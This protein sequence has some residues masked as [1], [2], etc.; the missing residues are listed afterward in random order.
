MTTITER[1]RPKNPESGFALSLELLLIALVL[2][3]GLISGWV[4]FRDSSG[5]EI[6]DAVAA[7]DA[8]I[9]GVAP[10]AQPYA[11]QWIT[12]AGTV[13]CSPTLSPQPA[14]CVAPV[15]EIIDPDG[16]PFAATGPVALRYQTG[17]VASTTLIPLETHTI[18]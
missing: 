2:V 18:F 14:T 9:V 12:G 13:G 11:Q 15:T 17:P 3:C 1:R 10:V 8:Y 5:A 7:I 4:K 16:T 6:K